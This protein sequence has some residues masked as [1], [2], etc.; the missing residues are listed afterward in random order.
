[1]SGRLPHPGIHGTNTCDP[2][3]GVWA[4]HLVD[5]E[6]YRKLINEKF[7]TVSFAPGFWDTHYK[8]RQLNSIA[9]MLNSLI[10]KSKG[11][12]FTLAPFIYVIASPKKRA[13]EQYRTSG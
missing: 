9:K 10:R 3:S 2:D 12:A 5:I 6:T 1:M 7:F 4:E 13:N 11:L 8:V